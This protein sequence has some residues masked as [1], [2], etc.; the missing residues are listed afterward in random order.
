MAAPLS[1]EG[2]PA[3]RC[4]RRCKRIGGRQQSEASTY[5]CG[6]L[7]ALLVPP[8]RPVP[9]RALASPSLVAACSLLHPMPFIRNNFT[10][11]NRWVVPFNPYLSLR[12]SCHINV[13]ICA[14]I[15][16]IK[17]LHKYGER[18]SPPTPFPACVLDL[19]FC[20]LAPLPACVTARAVP[21]PSVTP[22]AALLS[23]PQCSRVTIACLW[24]PLRHRQQLR[25]PPQ[26][27]PAAP[28]PRRR[29][30][31][32][33]PQR[34]A[35]ARRQPTRRENRSSRRQQRQGRGCVMRSASTR[36]AAT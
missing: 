16:A 28:R 13:E 24:L 1:S 5:T 9:R 15:K 14:S 31:A 20:C 35:A 32:D 7:C 33:Q 27:P 17:Y 34:P 12:F 30:L 19:A 11:D 23:N 22:P 29:P 21:R 2:P 4:E 36:T 8:P 25:R 18:F 10:F 3:T 6:G 26:P